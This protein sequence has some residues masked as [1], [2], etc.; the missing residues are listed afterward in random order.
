MT[1]AQ[2]V[3][4]IA[5]VVGS[6]R[7]EHAPDLKNS[8]TD[9]NAVVKQLRNR[10]Y[11]II[12]LNEPTRTDLLQTLARLR[13]A[14]NEAS[15]VVIF[16]SGHGLQIGTESYFL[17]REAPMSY[18][19]VLSAAIPLR[20]FVKAIS[21]KPRQKIIFFDACRTNPAQNGVNLAFSKP[22]SNPGGL[23]IAYASQPG[24]PSFDGAKNH[25]P[26][27]KALLKQ[28]QAPAQPLLTMLR[29]MRLD[30]VTETGGEQ[31]PWIQSTLLREAWLDAS[32]QSSSLQLNH[33]LAGN[34]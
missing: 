32:G 2:N 26:Y 25:S 4:H 6:S 10:G 17:T 29:N 27:A 21:D 30:V 12:Q 33:Q 19:E 14:A 7:Y 11:Q 22:I 28:L 9:A 23:L 3:S 18:P 8:V 31:I 5:L 34:M 13:L 15:Q 24:R 20:V 1:S 16:L